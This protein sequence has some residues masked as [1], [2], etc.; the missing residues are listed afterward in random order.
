ML[1][2]RSLVFFSREV[3]WFR[4]VQNMRILQC[5]NVKMRG[6]QIKRAEAC[7]NHL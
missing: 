2:Y 4:I 7:F 3:T 1:S 6:I 5:I